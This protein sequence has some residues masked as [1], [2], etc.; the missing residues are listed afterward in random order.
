MKK[1]S[2]TAVTCP[3]CG[4][5][6]SRVV[7]TARL[8]DGRWVRRRRCT[9]CGRAIYTSQLPEG[10]IEGWRIAWS[11]GG[12]VARLRDAP[13]ITEKMKSIAN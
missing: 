12:G 9:G 13:E 6:D 1:S 10:L 11:A 3:R 4:T 7:N 8:P 2:V 5:A